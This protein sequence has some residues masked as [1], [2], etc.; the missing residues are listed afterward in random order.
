M[1]TIGK[2]IMALLVASLLATACQ[3]SSSIPEG[4][5]EYDRGNIES[6]V[7]ELSFEPALPDFV[8][9]QV[10]FMISDHYTVKDTNKEALDVSFYTKGNDLLSIEFVEGPLEN[11]LVD[12]E[13]VKI[14]EQ[15]EGEYVDNSFA[16]VLFWQQ[17]KVCYKLSYRENVLGNETHT[18]RKVTKRDLL[19]V[20][21]SFHS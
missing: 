15:I 7:K 14:S 3:Q 16:K 9:M 11:P 4:F 12:T 10:D 19:Q 8:P 17:D 2:I 13:T 18:D 20:V 5:Y 6:A 1:K 21:R